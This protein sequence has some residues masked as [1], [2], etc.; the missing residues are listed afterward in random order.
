MGTSLAEWYRVTPHYL[1]FARALAF[2]SSATAVACGGKTAAE[3]PEL[4]DA[5]GDAQHRGDSEPADVA[6]FGTCASAHGG[7]SDPCAPGKVCSWSESALV[8]V[9]IA[10]DAGAEPNPQ[11]CGVIACGAECSCTDE[12]RSTCTC[13][14]LSLGPLPPPDLAM[15]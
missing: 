7:P 15:V 13:Q 1:R 9:C 4:V 11:T 5:A 3:D 8:P 10:P 2:V 6:T 14:G 12:S